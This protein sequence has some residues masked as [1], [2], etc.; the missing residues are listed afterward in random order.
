MDTVKSG[1]YNSSLREVKVYFDIYYYAKNGKIDIMDIED[2]LSFAFLSPL[3]INEKCVV[4][5]DDLEFEKLPDKILSIDFNLEIGNK[6][7]DESDLEFMQKLNEKQ[8]N[9]T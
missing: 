1:N 3:Q 8:H 6:F 2:K 9:N 4:Y 7:V 5:V